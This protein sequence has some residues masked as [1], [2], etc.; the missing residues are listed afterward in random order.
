MKIKSILGFAIALVFFTT[1]CTQ[2]EPMKLLIFTKTAGYHHKSISSG[3][4]ALEKLGL[5]NDLE[6]TVTND[7][8]QFTDE[9]LIAYQAVVFLNTTG[10]VLNTTQEGAFERY[11]QS[12]KGFVGVHAATDTEYDW[13]WYGAL[14]GAYFKNHPATQKATFSVQKNNHWATKHMPVTFEHTDEFYNFK[15]IS[16]TVEVLLT[17]DESSYE[18]GQNPDFHPMS[19]YHEFDGGRAFYTAMGHTNETYD[20]PLFLQH[21]WS[22]IEYALGVEKNLN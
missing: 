6:I 10:D 4:V 17:I 1:S 21:L 14:V 18:G 15:S 12:G 8:K 16:P 20:N 22:G 11:I 9:N 2:K 3:I 5:E 19:W 13:P 7:A